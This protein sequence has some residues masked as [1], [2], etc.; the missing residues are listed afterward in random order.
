[1]FKKANKMAKTQQNDKSWTKMKM[2]TEIILIKTNL[3]YE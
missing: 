3:Q 2:K 1:M